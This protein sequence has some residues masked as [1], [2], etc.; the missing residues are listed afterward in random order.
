MDASTPQEPA[1]RNDAAP[2]EWSEEGAFETWS[3]GES[4]YD[5]GD[6]YWSAVALPDWSN[7]QTAQRPRRPRDWCDGCQCQHPW[8]KDGYT[9]HVRS[10][11]ANAYLRSLQLAGDVPTINPLSEE[12]L[13]EVSKYRVSKDAH[14]MGLE[15]MER[16]RGCASGDNSGGGCC[17]YMLIG[18]FLEHPGYASFQRPSNAQ[19]FLSAAEGA[20]PV[21]KWNEFF[22]L[23]HKQHRDSFPAYYT[24]N[25]GGVPRYFY[26][27]FPLLAEQAQSVSHDSTSDSQISSHGQ[28]PSYESEQGTV[29]QASRN[30]LVS[31]RGGRRRHANEQRQTVMR[32]GR[33]HLHQ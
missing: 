18:G 16:L 24:P 12:P 20:D 2:A 25:T 28:P 4:L 17:N 31:G 5:G 30:R 3:N 26:Q 22:E 15:L 29:G 9:F 21:T 8:P 7:E 33:S 6:D 14:K 13:T 23:V 27:R 1:Q 10:R 11:R 32:F 19:E